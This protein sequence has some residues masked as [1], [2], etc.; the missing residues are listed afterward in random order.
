MK[1]EMY[2][3]Y[4]AAVKAFNRPMCFRS[5]GEALRSFMEAC[6]DEKTEFWKHSSDY[7]LHFVGVFD[8]D[9]GSVVIPT[10]PERVISALECV[11]RPLSRGE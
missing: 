8:D 4:D 1:H 9:S 7:S 2:C 6:R 10:A 5:R 3:V 11:E